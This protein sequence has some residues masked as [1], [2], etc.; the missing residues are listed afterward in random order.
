MTRRIE[1]C[2]GRSILPLLLFLLYRKIIFTGRFWLLYCV[3]HDDYHP[4]NICI[5]ALVSVT[6]FFTYVE[7]IPRSVL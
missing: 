4:Q 2:A 6:T 1:E 7:K 5:I 3:C